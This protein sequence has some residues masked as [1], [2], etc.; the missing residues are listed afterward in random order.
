MP[1]SLQGFHSDLSA[2][3][4]FSRLHCLKPILHLQNTI[5]DNDE[6]EHLLMATWGV[7]EGSRPASLPTSVS[8]TL[9]HLLMP[10]YLV[11]IA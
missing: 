3:C 9:Q 11:D 10:L 2:G 8:L 7:A 5:E 6:C 1:H 4:L